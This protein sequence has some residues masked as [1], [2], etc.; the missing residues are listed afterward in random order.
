ML[1]KHQEIGGAGGA[2]SVAEAEAKHFR[3]LKIGNYVIPDSG[4]IKLLYHLLAD[5]FIALCI[6]SY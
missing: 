6:N 1:T 3:A 5:D 2:I 4:K